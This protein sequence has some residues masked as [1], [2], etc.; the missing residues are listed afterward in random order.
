M[1]TN[2]A[3]DLFTSEEKNSV[4]ASSL[5]EEAYRVWIKDDLTGLTDKQKYSLMHGRSL[6]GDQALKIPTSWKNNFFE[7]LNKAIPNLPEIKSADEEVVYRREKFKLVFNLNDLNDNPN[8]FE[9]IL[10][11]I[12]S[13]KIK[14]FL[15]GVKSIKD[16]IYIS[17]ELCFPPEIA[18]FVVYIDFE[19]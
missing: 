2:N 5:Y 10:F 6:R 15:I 18:Y 11:S 12:V 19:I 13:N 16:E 1:P 17:N 8:K 4:L 7:K 9:D 3:Y 14:D